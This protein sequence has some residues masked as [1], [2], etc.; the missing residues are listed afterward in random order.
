MNLPGNTE[1]TRE[2]FEESSKAWRAN[3]IC[4]PDATYKY[5]KNAFLSVEKAKVVQPTA[6]RPTAQR[7][8]AERPTAQRPTAQ[9][10]TAERP[11]AQRPTA[12]RP[13]AELPKPRKHVKFTLLP[14][15]HMMVTR[16]QALRVI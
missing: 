13:T 2:F 14:S 6:Q 7:P 4:L 3:K 1:F 16:S 15:R 12:Q 11:T 9:R 10:P 8:T 5:K